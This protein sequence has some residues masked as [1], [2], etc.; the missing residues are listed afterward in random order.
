MDQK[1]KN[2]S[3]VIP[4]LESGGAQ[5]V[6]TNLC[7]QLVNLYNVSIILFRKSDP[8]Y[9]LDERIS[10]SHCLISIKP[11]KNS[12]ESLVINSKLIYRIYVKLRANKADCVIPFLTSANYLTVIAAKFAG[13]P[14]IVNVRNNP[15]QSKTSLKRRLARKL[16][17]PFANYVVVQTHGIKTYFESWVDASKLV[18]LPNPLSP[19]LAAFKTKTKRENF[20]LS[21]GRLTPQKGQDILIKAFAE[22]QQ[23]D[24]KL[25]IIGAGAKRKEYEALIT[26]LGMQQKIELAGQIKDIQ[27]F[28]NT[29]GIFV[30]PSRFEGFPNALIEALY[31]GAPSISTDCPSGPSELIEDGKNGFLITVDDLEALKRRLTILI[32]N[33][34]LREKF[35]AEAE[36]SVDHFRMEHV[37]EKWE[38]LIQKV[39][40]D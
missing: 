11:S 17:Y 13:I 33:A 5:R 22:V 15:Y 30:F 34:A 28:Y 25:V 1:R 39:I 4:D 18:I 31:F 10:V 21:V 27:R 19:N 20:V 38:K 7:N 23:N 16:I 12:L 6:V 35:S 2:I 36:S 24:W 40:S 32:E 3:F 8:F 37:L 29:A 14:S 9:P 26:D